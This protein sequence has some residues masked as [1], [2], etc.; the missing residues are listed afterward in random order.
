MLKQEDFD[1]QFDE[2]RKE[3]SD[4]E[5]SEPI[6]IE[7]GEE[8]EEKKFCT[9]SLDPKTCEVHLVKA[10]EDYAELD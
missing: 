4:L 8:I 5:L 2:E 3:L 1:R 10:D 6:E 9:C 7:E